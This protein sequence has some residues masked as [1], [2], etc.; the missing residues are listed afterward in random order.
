MRGHLK[1][2]RY[3]TQNRILFIL[4][5]CFIFSC[6]EP[7]WIDNK[8]A[9]TSISLLRNNDKCEV[10]FNVRYYSDSTFK[11]SFQSAIERGVNG[12]NCKII[13]LGFDTLSQT[14]YK[15]IVF[16]SIVKGF[17]Q[18]KHEYSGEQIL[19]PIEI[20]CDTSTYAR[21]KLI[22]YDSISQSIK[23]YESN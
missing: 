23:I 12:C 13:F 15:N 9:V 17:N 4:I 6:S 8:F 11:H 3:L 18:K 21:L 2:T 22:L 16:D 10:R 5:L 1:I 20:D 14:T 19:K 7:K